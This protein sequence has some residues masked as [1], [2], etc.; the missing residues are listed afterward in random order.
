MSQISAAAV[1]ELRKRTDMPLMECK[2]ALV[3]AEGDMDK[4][5]DIMRSRNRA[6]GDKRAGNETAEGRVGV[7][8]DGS[9]AAILEMRCE[10][11]PVTKSDQFIALVNDLAD[12]V[13]KINPSS[14]EQFN[15]EPLPSG[16]G[17][18]EERITEV[19][20]LIREN[21]KV[22]KFERLEGG[23]FGQYVHHDG[24]VG[25]LLQVN[26][27]KP[28]DE[29]L[30]DVCAHI[31]ALNPLYT[32]VQDAPADVVA[33]EK[34]LIETALKEDES[35]A[36]KPANILEKIVDGRM[37]NWYAEGVLL[38]QP[39]ANQAKYEKKTVGQVLSGAGFEI[40]KFV[41]YKVGEIVA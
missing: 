26:G 5:I 9:T 34:G 29:L 20:G 6:I 40:V 10:S 18:V 17:S 28:N 13:I 38:E 39:I 33:K 7:A 24:T 37:R 8:I 12:A 14:V 4:A 32:K 1:N 30:R 36:N 35:M 41:R 23:Q 2:S 3:E 15:S 27:A 11:A 22:N 19:I 31:A 21:M 25:V 16:S